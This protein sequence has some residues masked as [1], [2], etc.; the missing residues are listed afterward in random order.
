MLQVSP[1]TIRRR[2]VQFGLE[3]RASHSQLS[4]NQLDEI[5]RHFIH[6]HPHSGRRNY[7]GFLRF[8]GLWIQQRRIRDSLIR[9]DASG[10]ERRRRQALHRRRYNV[11]MPNSLWHIDGNHKLIR[12]RIVVHGGIDGY[13]RLPVYLQA[14]SNNR[15]DTV[16]ECF[17]EAVH[18]YGLPSRVRCDRGGENVAVSEYMLSHP[19][20]GPGRGS[21]I[22]GRSV[23]NQRIERLWRD[24]YAGCISVF[25]TL[26][27]TLEDAELLDR[28]S[29]TDLFCLHYVFL[30][31]LNHQ[32]RI[33][34]ESYGHHPLRTAGN[35][36]PYQVWISGMLLRNGDSA[37]VDGVENI[38][39]ST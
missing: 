28:E 1:R 32:L 6:S 37:A 34:Q 24:V 14:S 30:P 39:V 17:L 13:S 31:R 20:R 2:I 4:D 5:T 23:H 22:T 3:D 36:S 16:L 33:F 18:T 19:D 10:T 25:C 29:T 15:A 11:A 9:V 8:A 21:C 26:F 35:R 27:Y 38:E 12:W 7:E